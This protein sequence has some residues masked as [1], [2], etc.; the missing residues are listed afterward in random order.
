[1][2]LPRKHKKSISGCKPMARFALHEFSAP[3]LDEIQLVL[4]V[5]LL[6]IH[7]ARR[8]KLSPHAAVAQEF[9][10]ALAT[11]AGQPLQSLFLRVFQHGFSFVFSPR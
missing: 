4:C 3:A 10:E 2:G 7:A 6:E 8:I 11:G 5:G 1:V 9:R